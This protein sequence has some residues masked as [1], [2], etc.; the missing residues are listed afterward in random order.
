MSKVYL[1]PVS[2][3][4]LQSRDEYIESCLNSV[5]G[6][7]YPDP[8]T[9]IIVIDNM[10]HQYSIGEGFNHIAEQAEHDWIF[11]IGD[12]DKV[13]RDYVMSM[14]IA[15]N[16]YQDQLDNI[17]GVSSYCTM[18]DEHREQLSKKIVTAIWKKDYVL[19]HPWDETLDSRV[20]TEMFKRANEH[21]YY[22]ALNDW[23]YGYYYRQHQT[24]VSG[25]KF[26][27]QTQKSPGNP[28]QIYGHKRSG[29]HYLSVLLD[30]NFLHTGN[31]LELLAGH[32]FLHNFELDVKY[33]YIERNFTDVMRSLYKYRDRQSLNVDSFEDFMYST[34]AEMYDPE[35]TCDV[36]YNMGT[37]AANQYA[38]RHFSGQGTVDYFKN[39]DMTPQEFW[40]THRQH[41][42]RIADVMRNMLVVSYDRLQTDFQAEMDR[43]ADFLEV[44][45]PAE[46]EDVEERVGWFPKEEPWRKSSGVV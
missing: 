17:C 20:D 27:R 41:F 32:G 18:F 3:G 24:N 43:I 37:T 2:V 42:H 33:L 5:Y 23:H 13:A 22:I 10:D 34:Y 19:D 44:D 29:N 14:M 25:N 46:Y 35:V 21:G 4:I 9:D 28:V 1:P 38:D 31:P 12:D 15:L 16:H 30:R 7:V 36:E 6:Q 26:D 45:R 8:L 40:E 11:Y 39:I